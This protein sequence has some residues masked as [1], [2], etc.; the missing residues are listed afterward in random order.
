LSKFPN[1]FHLEVN[2]WKKQKRVKTKKPQ[3]LRLYRVFSVLA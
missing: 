3:N 1:Y 2:N